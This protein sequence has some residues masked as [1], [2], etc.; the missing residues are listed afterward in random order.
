MSKV[1]FLPDSISIFLFKFVYVH[2]MVLGKLSSKELH[3]ILQCETN[4]LEEQTILEPGFVL[5]VVGGGEHL[6]DTGHAEWEV[7][8]A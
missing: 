4:S 3:G 5:D 7:S 1:L 2:I 8:L 6:L